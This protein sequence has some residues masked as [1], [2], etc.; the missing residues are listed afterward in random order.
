MDITPIADGFVAD[1]AGVD[2]RSVDDAAFEAI[3]DAWLLHPIL[4]LRD[5]HADDEHLQAFSLRFGPLEYAPMG[6]ITETERAK[7]ANP[8]VTTISNILADGKPIGG[9]GAAEAAWHT[10]MSYIESPPTASLLYAVETPKEGGET[11]FCDMVAA[12]RA[13]PS[14]LAAKARQLR[15]KHDAAHDS[16]GK[17][18][19]GHRHAPDPRTAPGAVHPMVRR[20]PEN[21]TEA[22]F[23][24]RR[25]DA[26]VDG[27][28]LPASEALLDEIWRYV[29][30]PGDTWTQKWSVGDLVVWDNR[31]VMHRRA[32]FDPS[33]RRL[34]RRTQIRAA[35]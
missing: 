26:Y 7:L 35:P 20:H 16:I 30:L 21:G 28:S 11:H 2:L 8:Y 34:M 1:V 25:Q 12:L 27:L 10:D 9:L 22:L 6:R 17:L 5:Q 18:R 24:G 14:E 4:R 19:R 3:H 29:A 33:A 23:L 15:V 13:L 32:A 31:S